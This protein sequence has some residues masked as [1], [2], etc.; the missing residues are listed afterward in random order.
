MK[1]H[2]TT[3]TCFQ[4]ERFRDFE[5]PN[6][7]FW[8]E[9]GLIYGDWS[10]GPNGDGTREKSVSIPTPEAL[11][12]NQSLYLH[13]FVVKSGMSPVPKDPDYAGREVRKQRYEAGNK[14][15]VLQ[16]IHGTFQLNKYKKKHYKLTQNLLT[17]KT[18]QS[19]ED[20]LKAAQVK[21]EILNF[22]HPNLTIN[23]VNDYTAWT[24][25]RCSL[26]LNL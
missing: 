24:K 3:N 4:K 25:G 10:S 6:A 26:P 22:W 16:I 8:H 12:R 17:G 20:Q 15:V 21:Y 1:L 18:E 23:L 14:R 7:L 11:Q 13:A 9:E 5:D 19:E 2:A